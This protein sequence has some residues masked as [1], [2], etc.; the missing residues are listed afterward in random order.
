MVNTKLI[1]DVIRYAALRDPDSPALIYDGQTTTYA[2]LDQRVNRLANG[3]LEVARP[4]E[5]VAILAE[6]LPEY[7]DAYYGVPLAGMGLTF[8][9]YRLHPREIEKIL[10]NSGAEVLITEPHV[11]VRRRS[12]NWWSRCPSTLWP[13]SPPAPARPVACQHRAGLPWPRPSF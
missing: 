10:D 6:N 5:R 12:R 11:G 7:V 1:S 3:L 2:E 4:G 8:L 9:N 13:P